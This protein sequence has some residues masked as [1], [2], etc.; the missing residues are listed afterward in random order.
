[1]SLRDRSGDALRAILVP[2]LFAGVC[3]ALAI[4]AGLPGAHLLSQ[5]VSRFGRN[6][7]LVLSL[8]IP[9]VAGLGLNFAIVIGAMA[10]QA[11]L[12]MV[13]AWGV[14]GL[15][16][17]GLAFLVAFP[18]AVGLGWLVGLLFNRARGKEM[19][20]GLI[21]GYFANAPYQIV[22]IFLVGSIIP[23]SD[24]SMVK[25]GPADAAGELTPGVGL[26]NTI[27]F[28]DVHHSLDRVAE[29]T[30]RVPLDA[31]NPAVGLEPTY[32]IIRL[33]G[34]VLILVALLCLFT[35]L[36]LRTKLGQELRAMGQDAHVAEVHGIRVAR[37]RVV[38][39]I[40]SIV[41]AAWGQVI[42]LQ[43]WGNMATYDVHANVGFFAIGALLVSG[44]SERRATWWQ[45]LL[46]VILFHSLQ[47]VLP[48][49]GARLFPAHADIG[50]YLRSALSYA[51][52]AMSLVVYGIQQRRKAAR[53]AAED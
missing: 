42:W 1:M 25:P 5:I 51:V 24:V 37:N 18:I 34:G 16:G 38:A 4:A 10:G 9:I 23:L 31:G 6:G 48:Q 3:I 20:T 17:V 46:G 52:I 40:I 19:I 11:A 49:A 2:V 44:A 29:I 41:L 39:T 26:R 27:D 33:P 43:N 30:F 36:F 7:F 22:F 45:A 28:V 35:T 8:I 50:E 47:V 21:A 15:S 32:T 12:I 53:R 14:G 13:T